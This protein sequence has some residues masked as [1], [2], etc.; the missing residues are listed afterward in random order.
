VPGW[1]AG[2][3]SAALWF[4]GRL[5]GFVRQTLPDLG[6][7]VIDGGLRGERVKLCADLL[8]AGRGGQV[9]G[10]A[11]GDE[12]VEGAALRGSRPIMIS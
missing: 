1:R 3:L 11:R 10:G 9:I 2:L 12:F 5:S 8:V 4:A 7:F 6:E